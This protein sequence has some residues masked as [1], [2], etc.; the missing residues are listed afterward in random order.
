MPSAAE[1]RNATFVQVRAEAKLAWIMPSAAESRNATFVQVRAEAKLAWNM[2]S[3][4]KSLKEENALLRTFLLAFEGGDEGVYILRLV[5]LVSCY[6]LVDALFVAV[7]VL[8]ADVEQE[9][10]AVIGDVQ[11]EEIEDFQLGFGEVGFPAADSSSRKGNP[12][13]RGTSGVARLQAHPDGLHL[14]HAPVPGAI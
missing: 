1:S 2:P 12:A 13:G 11:A 3:A 5:G 4:A 7:Q 14:R 6:P 10:N 9:C 8:L